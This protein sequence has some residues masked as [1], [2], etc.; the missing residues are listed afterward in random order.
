METPTLADSASALP[1]YVDASRS[2][3]HAVL[4]QPA[5]SVALTVLMVEA[6]YGTLPHFLLLGFILEGW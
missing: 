1:T 5:P 4:Q 2:P 3:S 6:Y